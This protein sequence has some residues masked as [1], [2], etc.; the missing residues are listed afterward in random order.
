MK[1]SKYVDYTVILAALSNR[2]KRRME[3][4]NPVLSRTVKNVSLSA[5]HHAVNAVAA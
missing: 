5:K 1:K 2:K 3:K 4:Q